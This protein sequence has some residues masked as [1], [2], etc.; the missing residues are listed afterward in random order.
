MHKALQ[1]NST[2]KMETCL[3]W[4]ATGAAERLPEQVAMAKHNVSFVQA[5]D[6]R[7]VP[8]CL[9][10]ASCSQALHRAVNT[11]RTAFPGKGRAGPTR[12]SNSKP[13][14]ESI[15][16]TTILTYYAACPLLNSSIKF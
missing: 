7:A 12:F 8:R 1:E 9:T 10:P 14:Q 3:L 4:R 15:N 16:L 11:A 5:P 13:R 2:Q 6:S